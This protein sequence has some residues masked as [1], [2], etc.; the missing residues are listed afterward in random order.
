MENVLLLWGR[1]IADFFSPFH[2]RL[3]TV[4]LDAPKDPT[5]AKGKCET[6]S[7]ILIRKMHLLMLDMKDQTAGGGDFKD[8]DNSGETGE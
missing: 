2:S 6:K 5:T 8:R 3:T 1:N 7:L 4:R